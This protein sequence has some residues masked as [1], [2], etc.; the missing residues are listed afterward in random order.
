M[1]EDMYKVIVERPRHGRYLKSEYP[2]PRDLE[3]SPNHEGLKKRHR[4]RKSLNENLNPLERFLA[5]QINRPWDRVF[6]ELCNSIDRRNTVQQHIHQHIDDFVVRKVVNLE[7]ELYSIE[8]WGGHRSLAHRWQSKLYVDP[9][10]GILRKNIFRERLLAEEKRE[11]SLVKVQSN[12][13]RRVVD[14]SHQLHQLDG[15]WFL[16]TLAKV[17]EKPAKKGPDKPKS[18]LTVPIDVIRKMAA[19][20]CPCWKDE[21]N[22]RSNQSLFGDC[23]L[24]ASAKRQLNSRELM[25]YDVHNN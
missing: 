25:R 7:G 2:C 16:V 5:K 24:Y 1:R 10:T 12:Q 9:A 14:A 8:S 20:D 4:Y 17:P 21:K 13:H 19:W 11:R 22:M 6:S 3:E 15:I 18:R 23:Q